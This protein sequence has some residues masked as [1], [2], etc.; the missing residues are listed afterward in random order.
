VQRRDRVRGDYEPE[1]RLAELRSPL[2]HDRLD[3]GALKGDRR[4]EPAYPGSDD[5]RAHA[6]ILEALPPALSLA[7]LDDD[8]VRERPSPITARAWPRYELDLV[9]SE[10][11]RSFGD[12]CCDYWCL[13]VFPAEATHSQR[14]TLGAWTKLRPPEAV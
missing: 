6:S 9:C 7:L 1:S 2:D 5:N 12:E 13:V 3:P 14:D 11:G 4:P 8:P 10:N